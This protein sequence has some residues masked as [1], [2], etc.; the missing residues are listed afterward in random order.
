MEVALC[1][2]SCKP[3]RQ[4]DLRSITAASNTI[5]L[6]LTVRSP[7]LPMKRVEALISPPPS[8]STLSALIAMFPKETGEEVP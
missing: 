2:E 3:S 8:T 4:Q 5:S 7:P 1:R 6:A